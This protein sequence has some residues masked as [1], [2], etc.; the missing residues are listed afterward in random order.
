MPRGGR[1]KGAGR[2]TAWKSGCSF[3]ETTVIRV[4][5]S[6]KDEILDIAHRLDAGEEIDLVSKSIKE[7]NSYL[8][9]RVLELEKQL[10]N[11]KDSHKEIVTKSKEKIEQ[12]KLDIDTKSKIILSGQFLST[13][14]LGLSKNA[15]SESK[16][17]RSPEDFLK[18]TQEYDPNGIGWM[19]NPDGKGFIPQ[20]NLTDN[21]T[22]K[23][24]R[25]IA[26]NT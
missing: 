12:G 19:L 2:K 4:P 18:W 5:R 24:R 3:E 11:Q 10:L 6:L 9:G 26:Q 15:V 25:W 21:E 16:K 22:I 23:L 17:R 20:N 7:R 13:K 1:R 14:R 8:E